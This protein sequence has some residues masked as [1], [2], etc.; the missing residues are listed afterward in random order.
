M[1]G[2]AR[3]WLPIHLWGGFKVSVDDERVCQSQVLFPKDGVSAIQRAQMTSTPIE[4]TH[5]IGI[6]CDFDWCD[7]R[8]PKAPTPLSSL[9]LLHRH[10]ASAQP[11]P[12]Y[13]R[14]AGPDLLRYCEC[15]CQTAVK[16]LFND[17]AFAAELEA[18]YGVVLSAA[19]SMN[20]GRLLPQVVY[21]T[22]AY[23]DLVTTPCPPYPALSTSRL[24][25]LRCTRQP[26]PQVL[27]TALRLTAV[28]G[29][30]QLGR[31]QDG[32]PGR[33]LRPVRQLW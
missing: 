26:A 17:A 24:R 7:H 30:G 25:A 20:W 3:H 21:H 10:T 33:L 13:I 2:A 27:R 18:E 19:N 29:S 28:V 9:A 31:D 23:L 12:K 32:R 11:P 14:S 6:D 15:R 5:T 1:H 16:T 4:T 8:P 22:S